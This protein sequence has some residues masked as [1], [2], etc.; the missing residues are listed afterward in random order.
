MNVFLIFSLYFLSIALCA[1]SFLYMPK[2]VIEEKYKRPGEI[3]FVTLFPILNIL[4]LIYHIKI[5]KNK[6]L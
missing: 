5:I 2:K 6:Q 3:V 1:F 4:I